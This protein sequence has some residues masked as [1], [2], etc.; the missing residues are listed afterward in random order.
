M[1]TEKQF[2]SQKFHSEYTNGL[3]TN[4]FISCYSYICNVVEGCLGAFDELS[5][6]NGVHT[7][8]DRN[9]MP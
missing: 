6:W 2:K 9:I 4:T 7:I 3:N 1:T 5:N 8:N